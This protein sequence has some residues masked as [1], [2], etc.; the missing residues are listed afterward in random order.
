[1]IFFTIVHRS[2]RQCGLGLQY[3]TS[4]LSTGELTT[5]ADQ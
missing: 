4:T 5:F 1:M 2:D 3:S